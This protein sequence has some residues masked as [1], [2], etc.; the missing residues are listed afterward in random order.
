MPKTLKDKSGSGKTE[1][2]TAE[3]RAE[4]F[5]D[6]QGTWCCCPQWEMLSA[7][8]PTPKWEMPKEARSRNEETKYKRGLALARGLTYSPAQSNH[9]MLD[10]PGIF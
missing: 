10:N 2:P 7:P 1:K 9:L 6:P 4:G 5:T 3:A 8:L